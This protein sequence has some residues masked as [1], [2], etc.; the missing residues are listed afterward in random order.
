[1][2]RH[3]AVDQ[4]AGAPQVGGRVGERLDLVVGDHVGDPRILTGDVCELTPLRPGD[5]AELTDQAVRHGPPDLVREPV[6][7]A[8]GH[9]Q[10]ETGVDIDTH[11]VG[12]D[13]EPAE[14]KSKPDDWRWMYETNVIGL[15]NITKALLP[16][17]V[18][19]GDGLILNVG[20]TAGRAAY[21]GGGGYT[22]AKHGTKVVTQTLR[23]ELFDQPVRVTEVAPGMVKT[24]EFAMVRFAGD[25]ERYDAVYAGIAEP[26]MAED[27]ADAISW[28]ATR[29]RHV[30]IDE[31][32]IKPRAQASRHRIHRVLDEG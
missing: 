13:G 1:M 12:V 7:E 2:I 30:N 28:V 26:L 25:K 4:C 3:R 32:V 14:A 15:L 9:R 18:A 31:L 23:L 20:S 21:E 17:L 29:P 19:S 16:A 10:P 8:G 5:A 27:I 22:A 24:E 11:P 6:R